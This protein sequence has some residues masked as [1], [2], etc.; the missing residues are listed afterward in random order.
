MGFRIEGHLQLQGKEEKAVCILRETGKKEFLVN[1]E[2]YSRFSKHIGRYPCVVIAP[3]DVE[4]IIGGSEDRRR[5]VDTILSQLDPVYLQALIHY[6]RILQQRNSFLRAYNEGS[7]C[8]LSVLDVLDTQLAR[9]GDVVYRKRADFLQAFLPLA[10][11]GYATISQQEEPVVLRYDSELHQSPLAELLRITRQKDLVVQRTSAG[12]HR[13]DLVFSLGAQTFKSIASQG[14]RKSLLFALKLAE[15]EILKCEK[16]FSPLLL[17]DDVFE[18]LD[19]DRIA[20]LLERVCRDEETQVFITDTSCTR[21]RDGLERTGQ[22][23]QI[24]QV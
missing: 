23:V 5:F 10:A 22:S 4:L 20:N 8:D 14:Q 6:T 11:Q 7:S 9:E 16:G 17:L 3:D 12:V 24:I 18:K 15:M 2:P 13:D 19:D 21:L 1:D